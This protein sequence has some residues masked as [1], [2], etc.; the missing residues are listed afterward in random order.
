M[1]TA[2]KAFMEIHFIPSAF[3]GDTVSVPG[4]SIV[5][6]MMELVLKTSETI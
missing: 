1:P 3:R 2:S 4:H 6:Q 5:A